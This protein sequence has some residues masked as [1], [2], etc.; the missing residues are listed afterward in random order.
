MTKNN[1][2]DSGGADNSALTQEQID[3]L[4]IL[5]DVPVARLNADMYAADDLDGGTEGLSGSGNLNYLVLQ[6]QQTNDARQVNDPFNPDNNGAGLDGIGSLGGGVPGA[7]GGAGGGGD[8][9]GRAV[10]ADGSMGDLDSGPAGFDGQ[11]ADA[12]GI[13][14]GTGSGIAPISALSF[15]SATSNVLNQRYEGDEFGDTDI[16]NNYDAPPRRSRD[17]RWPRSSR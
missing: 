16:T 5:Q 11:N 6:S 10:D 8:A 15:N 14:G 2:S 12:G 17:A 1:D 4:A 3:Y 13:G 7:A 9:L